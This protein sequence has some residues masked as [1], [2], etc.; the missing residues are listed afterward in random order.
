MA[1][2]GQRTR[3]TKDSRSEV[4]KPKAMDELE[5]IPEETNTKEDL[6]CTPA[7]QTMYRGLLA[8]KNWLQSRT[9]FQC[10]FFFLQMCFKGSVSNIWLCEG[11]EQ[12]CETTEVAASET[13]VLP[14]HW[15]IEDNWISWCIPQKQR[16]W[17]FTEK[18]GS[19]LSR[20]ARAIIHGI[21]V[22]YESQNIKKTVLSTTMAE[23]CSF[24]KCFASCQFLR[25]LWK[26]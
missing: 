12:T 22:D 21:L 6:H 2:T 18:H 8:K 10:C 1:F 24:M 3:W 26:D 4:S 15:T 23:L 16:R 11:S 25:G 9:H 7:M 13:S 14:T 5:E 17:I 20:I 19:I